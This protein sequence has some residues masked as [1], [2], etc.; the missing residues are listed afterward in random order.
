MYKYLFHLLVILTVAAQ[1]NETIYSDGILAKV[2]GKIIT[3]FELNQMT[4]RAQVQIMQGYPPEIA[5]KRIE[6][7]KRSA[8]DQFINNVIILDEFKTK[9]FEVPKA[10]IDK[11]LA[12]EIDQR[13]RGNETEFYTMLDK[14]GL[15][16]EEYREQIEESL[17]IE[18]MVNENVRRKINVTPVDI[19]NYYN[20]NINKFTT[21]AEIRSAIILVAKAGKT[22]DEFKNI[23]KTIQEA[24]NKNEDFGAL[25]DKHSN[26]PGS[27]KG[28]DLGFK[29]LNEL[30]DSLRKTVSTLKNGET[31]GPITVGENAAFIKVLERRGGEGLPLIQVRN[32]IKNTLEDTQE[33][34]YYMEFISGL[35]KKASIED[36]TK[37]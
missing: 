9:K 6:E 14:G 36:F 10:L 8:L 35:R 24:L 20:K 12:K 31:Y 5:K 22:D 30:T 11:E 29:K 28:G 37:K 3:N 17:A 16:M 26:M 4:Q 32:K 33:R 19:S 23:V 1:A 18:L 7:L 2:N 13:S 25:A 27:P 15:S 34:K 21:N